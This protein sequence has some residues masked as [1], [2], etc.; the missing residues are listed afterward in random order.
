MRVE[1]TWLHMSEWRIHDCT[2]VGGGY[3]TAHV[4]VEDT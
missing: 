4:W 2:C 1:A 3:K